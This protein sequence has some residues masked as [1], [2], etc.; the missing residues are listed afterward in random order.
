MKPKEILNEYY[1][2]G[3]TYS[4]YYMWCQADTENTL[5]KYIDEDCVIAYKKGFLGF[6]LI[7][8]G[9]KKHFAFVGVKNDVYL[10]GM[11][12]HFRRI[13]TMKLAIKLLGDDYTILNDEEMK[14]IKDELI[15][16]KL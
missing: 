10:G 14:K 8:K 13:Y 12:Y 3:H 6:V 1:E 15:F 7:I 5:N 4:R 2:K 11:G 16:E 9:K